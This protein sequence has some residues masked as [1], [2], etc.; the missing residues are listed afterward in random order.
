M[1]LFLRSGPFFSGPLSLAAFCPICGTGRA[2]KS[3]AFGRNKKSPTFPAPPLADSGGR[4]QGGAQASVQ[5]QDGGAEPFAD[6]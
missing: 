5:R 4:G 3:V 1:L 6:Q 2:V